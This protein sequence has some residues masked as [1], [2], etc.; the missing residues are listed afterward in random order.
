MTLTDLI[1]LVQNRLSTLNNQR[2]TAASHG[3]VSEVMRIDDLIAETQL[4][5]DQL[6]TLS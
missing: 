1:R 4:T 3:D 5:L 2:S 6:H